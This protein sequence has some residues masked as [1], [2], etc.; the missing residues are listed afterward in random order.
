MFP[1]RDESGG[2]NLTNASHVAS[3]V[4]I[5]RE[6]FGASRPIIVGVYAN[7]HSKLGVSTPEYVEQVLLA[8]ISCADGVSVYRHPNPLTD[9][10]KH[11]I[12][13][14]LYGNWSATR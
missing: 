14:R 3:E 2:A 7:R 1:Y 12:V 11:A 10:E 8:A 13:K 6:R 4:K 9:P 5:L